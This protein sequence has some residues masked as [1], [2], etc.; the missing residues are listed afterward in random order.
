MIEFTGRN[1]MRTSTYRVWIAV[2][3]EV[4]AYDEINAEEEALSVLDVCYDRP[5]TEAERKRFRD[6]REPISTKTE[7]RRNKK[8]ESI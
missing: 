4:K 1:K 8:W 6:M 5:M 2:P 7:I 3:V